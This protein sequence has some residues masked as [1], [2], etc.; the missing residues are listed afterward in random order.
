MAIPDPVWAA[1]LT[2]TG[3]AVTFAL[4][5]IFV[6]AVL[7]P[8]HEL[9]R[10]IARVAY[11]LDYYANQMHGPAPKGDEARDAFRAHA[12][13]LRE[14]S[15]LVIMYATWMRVLDLPSR[16]DVALPSRELIGHSNRPRD[17][18]PRFDPDRTGD[19]RHLL[20]ISHVDEL[21]AEAR[22]EVL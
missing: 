19:I 12:C 6:K 5:Q 11:S 8:V 1:A 21:V 15:G 9:K 18:D 17:P 20:R 22:N 2:V 4:G 7:E 16:R 3:G 14:L 10:E 13:R